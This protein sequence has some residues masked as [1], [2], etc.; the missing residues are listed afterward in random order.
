MRHIPQSESNNSNYCSVSSLPYL[1]VQVHPEAAPCHLLMSAAQLALTRKNLV[2]QLVA[3][4]G[5]PPA[6][7]TS[8]VKK[9][10]YLGQYERKQPDGPTNSW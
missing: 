8:A 3:L 4:S 5:G 7:D 1:A 10:R 6:F 9:G 2:E